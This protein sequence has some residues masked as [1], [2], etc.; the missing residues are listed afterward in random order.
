MGYREHAD[1][2]LGI[3]Q[4][5]PGE[6]QM[7][8]RKETRGYCQARSA[9]TSSKLGFQ[10]LGLAL[11]PSEE[12][13]AL[14]AERALLRAQKEAEALATLEAEHAAAAGEDEAAREKRL[15]ALAAAVEAAVAEIRQAGEAEDLA[16]VEAETKAFEGLEE[17]SRWSQ[18]GGTGCK[19][20]ELKTLEELRDKVLQEPEVEHT[21]EGEEVVHEEPVFADGATLRDP[22]PTRYNSLMI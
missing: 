1:Q 13:V 4:R 3:H 15:A 5:Y 18:A 22:V 2:L 11:E 19:V 20:L 16:A 9:W 10:D 6:A 21:E 12:H 14:A 17:K 8:I 7:L